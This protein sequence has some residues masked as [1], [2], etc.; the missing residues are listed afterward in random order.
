LDT[1]R[2]DATCDHLSKRLAPV[3]TG[4]TPL[5]R[6]FENDTIDGLA[7]AVGSGPR[8]VRISQRW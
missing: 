1:P 4:T 6:A 2:D 5:S 8:P 7:G 3:S